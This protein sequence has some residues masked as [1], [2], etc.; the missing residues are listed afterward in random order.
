MRLTR[1]ELAGMVAV[2][3]AAAQAPGNAPESPAQLAQ[4]ALADV[5]KTAAEIRKLKVPIDTEPAFS[6]KAQ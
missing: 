5:R 3:A 6:F 4:S 2:G 1:R